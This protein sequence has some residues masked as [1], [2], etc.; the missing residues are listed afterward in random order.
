MEGQGRN[1]RPDFLWLGNIRRRARYRM[2]RSISTMTSEVNKKEEK[3]E[4]EIVCIDILVQDEKVTGLEVRAQAE[5]TY[6]LTTSSSSPS[7]PSLISHLSSLTSIL[8]SLPPAL[9][10]LGRTHHNVLS[11]DTQV[12]RNVAKREASRSPSCK[13]RAPTRGRRTDI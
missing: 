11:P 8:D 7:L 13:L 2:D 10:H 3:R 4:E 1:R 5:Y 12:P 6:H 9:Y